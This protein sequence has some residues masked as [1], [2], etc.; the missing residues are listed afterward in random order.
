[1]AVVLPIQALAVARFDAR[2]VGIWKGQ[3]NECRLQG[4]RGG[5]RGKVTRRACE[6]NIDLSSNMHRG[7]HVVEKG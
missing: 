4:D 7:R 2:C 3:R 5:G 6:G 1:V